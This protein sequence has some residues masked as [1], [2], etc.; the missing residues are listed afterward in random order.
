MSKVYLGMKNMTR[1]VFGGGEHTVPNC[2]WLLKC[3]Y[4][5]DT[6][7]CQKEC[8]DRYQAAL[9]GKDGEGK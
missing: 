7:K 3:Q 9:N 8:L 1:E 4:P 2:P 5:L 6:G